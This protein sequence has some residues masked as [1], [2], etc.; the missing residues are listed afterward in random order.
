MLIRQEI[1]V[2][3]SS[4]LALAP[5]RF[6]S[7]CA[8][9]S[10]FPSL[11]AFQWNLPPL[12]TELLWVQEL[13]SI[14]STSAFSAYDFIKDVRIVADTR[15]GIL[16]LLYSDNFRAKSNVSNHTRKISAEEAWR[17]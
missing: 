1:L 4:W 14:A 16:D 17:A 9:W 2:C 5:I 15:R 12:G 7:L 13:K 8:A 6:L 3:L 11:V 10:Q